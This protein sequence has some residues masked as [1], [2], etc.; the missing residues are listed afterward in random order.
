MLGELN[1]AE[2]DDLL[3]SQLTGRIGCHSEGITYVVPV[4]Y[5][6]EDTFIYAH[7]ARGM[8]IEMMHKNP[9]ICFEVDDV[10]NLISWQSVIVWGRYEEITDMN[11]KVKVMQKLIN[12]VMPFIN[13]DSAPPSHGFIND[14]SEVGD[15]V[16]LVVYKIVISHKTG[17]FEKR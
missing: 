8:K 16:E 6:Y 15:T 12:R 17:R 5:I 1:N 11:E 4:N 9:E 10:R 14:E 13:D 2:M 7:S 3:K